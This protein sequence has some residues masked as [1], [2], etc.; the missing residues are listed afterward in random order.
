MWSFVRACVLSCALTASAIAG[1]IYQ[2]TIDVSIPQGAAGRWKTVVATD[3]G[4]P[5]GCD[6]LWDITQP[7]T[8][9]FAVSDDEQQIVFYISDK[10]VSLRCDWVNFTTRKRGRVKLTFNPESPDP[11]TPPDPRPPDPPTPPTPPR[12]D[13]L[14]GAIYDKAV[15]V[16]RPEDCKKMAA[17]Y[18]AVSKGLENARLWQKDNA[19]QG[20]PRYF[21]FA[22][23]LSA[24][25]QANQAAKLDQ[26]WRDFGDFMFTEATKYGSTIEAVHTFYDQASKGLSAAG[27]KK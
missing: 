10:P 1:E 23:A 6:L 4:V 17:N 25:T 13:G 27:D 24:V 12:P 7:A 5:P 14:A 21:T 8:K 22:Q 2:E 11:P 26:S 16:G 20:V 3:V 18:A 9:T 19:F 15:A